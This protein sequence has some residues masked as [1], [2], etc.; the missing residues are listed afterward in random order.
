MPRRLH[1]PYCDA[2]VEYPHRPGVECPTAP[3]P[4]IENPEGVQ[5]RGPR[6]DEG[7]P[8]GEAVKGDGTRVKPTYRK[9]A[10]EENIPAKKTN[11]DT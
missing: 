5:Y 2:I 4:D 11:H 1:C 7:R 10:Q 9:P 6:D 8:I 3:P